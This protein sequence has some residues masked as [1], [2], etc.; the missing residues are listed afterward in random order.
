MKDQVVFNWLLQHGTNTKPPGEWEKLLNV[1]IID[2]DGWK[3][4]KPYNEPI[5]VIEFVHRASYSTIQ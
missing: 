5:S 3:D 2:A 1:R 4:M